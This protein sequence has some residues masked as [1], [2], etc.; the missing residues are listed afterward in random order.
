MRKFFTPLLFLLTATASMGQNLVERCGTDERH[1]IL[2]QDSAY[3]AQYAEKVSKVK[4]Y[5]KDHN[6][7]AKADCDEILYLPVAVHFQDVGIDYACA[8]DM[9]LSQVET[10]NQDFGGT[11]PDIDKWEEGRPMRWPQIQNGESCV[12]FCLATL[13]H[14]N[15]SGIAEGE[16][17]VTLNDTDGSTD[18]LPM[19]S[20]YVNFFVRDMGNP[21]G[22][23]P[24]GGNGNGD[25]VVCGITYF[26]SVSCGG[27]TISG[28]YNLGRTITHEVGHYLSLSHPFDN[29]DC[30]VD[31]DDI[32]D[33]PITNAPTYG[34]YAVGEEL[35]NCVDPILWP[36]YMDYCDDACLYMFSQEQVENIE[37][38]VNTSLDN[39]LN[40]AT[41]KCEDAA[42]V[43]FEVDLASTD[44]SC[45]GN[46]GSILLAASGG[47]EPYIYSITGGETNSNNGNFN[48][49]PQGSYSVF[50]TDQQ[51]CEFTE[52]VEL[53][54][55]TP[56]MEVLTTKNSFC[57]DNSGSL[58]VKVNYDTDFQYKIEGLTSLQDTN[59]F[60]NLSRGTYVVTAQT[61]TGC[62][63][64]IEVEI[65]DDSDLNFI[66]R[67]VQPVNCPLFDNGHIRVE[68]SN[69][70]EPIDWQLDN[71]N[72]T[73]NGYYDNLSPGTYL[74]S[75]E[76][77]R[78][79]QLE[80]E[81]KVGISYLNIGDDCPCD[82][83]IPNAMTP[84]G[85]GLNDLLTVVPSCPISDYNLQIFT[86]WG[87][88]IFESNDLDIRWNGGL[89]GYYVEAGIYFYRI[90]Y[91]WGESR[92]E[93]LEVQTEN[94]YVTI[95]K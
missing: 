67:S 92:N 65:G 82:V 69:G 20:G 36:S 22:Y 27:N 70:L 78:G 4:R 47:T 33:T 19:W 25:G 37:A 81:F 53:E 74:L 52:S 45:P 80:Q 55:E 13:N 93:S 7:L 6:D 35:V 26:G 60:D 39:L 29:P 91:R 44:E 71:G 89:E 9:A 15:G 5:L 66:V 1:A 46:D 61:S 38:Y 58:S 64:S 31:G 95:L 63:S 24:L 40:S 16:W 42:C 8:V 88:L 48:N 84:D 73:N 23:S 68:L 18:N 14:P 11:N 56:T 85:D 72:R 34:C 83:Y 32:D 59:F 21:L 43:Q 12:Q 76:D 49:L 86:R 17:A 3:A 62:S 2:M 28:Q 77:S 50:V 51:G 90:T 10:L 30:A 57:G 75:V 94:G 87:Q 41:I 54:R 79:C